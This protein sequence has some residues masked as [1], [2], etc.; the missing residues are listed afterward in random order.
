[1]LFGEHAPLAHH[2]ERVDAHLQRQA[3]AVPPLLYVLE[4]TDG[5]GRY[6]ADHAS[7]LERFARGAFGRRLPGFRPA[8]GNDPATRA[9]RGDEEK[10]ENA[11]LPPPGK[12]CTLH[13]QDL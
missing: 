5:P 6:L 7:F 10:F 11:A 2:L 1:M 12:R 3:F 9:A 4:V 13:V 8:F